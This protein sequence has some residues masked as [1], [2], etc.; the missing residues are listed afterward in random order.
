MEISKAVEYGRHDGA[1]LAGDL[2]LPADADNRPAIIAVHGGGFQLGS[3]D[4]YQYLGP[5]LAAHGYVVFSID[6]RLTRGGENLYPA[7][8]HDVRAA[9]QWLRSRAAELKIDP[10]RIALIGDSAGAHLS[11]LVALAGDT[12]AYADACRDDPYA[13]VTRK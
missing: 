1:R 8:V 13:G 10:A 11:S 9:V 7:A 6:Y 4:F 12:P 2:Y 5:C 3:R